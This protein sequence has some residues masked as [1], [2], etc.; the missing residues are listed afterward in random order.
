MRR[1]FCGSILI[2]YYDELFCSRFRIALQ[3]QLESLRRDLSR[4]D[5]MA[6]R[7]SAALREKED[8]MKVTAC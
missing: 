4:R 1:G 3:D 8:A 6:E 7:L 2:L 5:S